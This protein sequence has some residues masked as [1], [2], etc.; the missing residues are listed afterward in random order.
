[1]RCAFA[2]VV[3]FGLVFGNFL[4]AAEPGRQ[5]QGLGQLVVIDPQSGS[6]VRLNLARYH[7]NVVLHPPVA[8]VQIDQSF[9]NPFAMQQEGTFVFNLPAGASVSRFAMYTTHIELVE[10]ELIDRARA[11]DIYQSIVS[12]RRDPAILEQIGDNLFKMRVF[13]IFGR[14][15]KRI[16]LDF[17]LPIVEQE[18][19]KYTFE[20][21]LMSDLE[22]VWDFA[23]TGAIR[24]PNI[25]GTASSP[26]HSDLTFDAAENGGLKF[27]FRKQLYRPESAFVVQ[28]QQK[29]PVEAT[30]RSFATSPPRI[31]KPTDPVQVN[32]IKTERHCEFLATISPQ[33]L[34]KKDQQ[35]GQKPLPADLLILADTSGGIADRE[36]LRLAVQAIV[37]GLRT[38]DRFAV[39]CA[40]VG[41]RA[42]TRGWVA[43]GSPG[44]KEALATFDHELF[45]GETRFE[46]SLA[47]ALEFLP[48]AET[49]R[50]RLVVYVGDGAL[51][52]SGRAPSAAVCQSIVA[53]LAQAQ[54]RLFAV[55][56]ENDPAGR[57][58]FEQ[59]AAAS[60]GQ[61]LRIGAAAGSQE[62]LT[63]WVQAGFAEPIKI[64][65]V[66]AEGVAQDD[67]FVPTAWVLGR[68]LQILGRRKESGP[69]KLEVT[70]ERRGKAESHEWTLE[71]KNDPDDMF[72]GR[73]WAQRK[74]DQLRALEAATDASPARENAVA[75]IVSLSQEWT[76]LSPHTAFL[77]LEN[78][79]EY[80]KYGIT[81]QTRHQYWKPGDAVPYEPLPQ[82]AL[83][84]LTGPPRVASEVTD[85]DF[86][87]VLA[88][89][90]KALADR[91]PR[92]AL[93][94]LETVS[95]SR[96]APES[97]EFEELRQSAV[98][99]LSRSDLLRDLG[100]WRGWFEREHSIGFDV[101]APELVW[102]L[103]YGYGARGHYGDPQLASLAKHVP[104]PAGEMSLR[105]FADWVEDVSGLAVWMDKQTLTDEGINLDQNVLVTGI[106][107]MSLESL[108]KHVLG[109]RQMTHVFENGVLK[110]TTSS[111]A[112]EKLSTRLYPVSDLVLSTNTTDYLLLI[113]AD[114]D[115]ELLTNRRLEEKLDRKVSVDFDDAPL[116]EAFR[117]IAEK[118]EDNFIIDQQTL[119]DEG[120]ALDQ[121]V[122]LQR[123]NVPLRQIL[124]LVCEPIQLTTSIE[125]EAVVVTTS[126]R[127]GE[128]LH[129]RIYSAQG[130]VYE[131]PPEVEK[132]RRQLAVQQLG[133]GGGMGGGMWNGMGG[134][135]MGGPM[136]GGM[137]VCLG[138]RGR[139]R[140]STAHSH[141][142]HGPA[143]LQPVRH[144]RR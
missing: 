8:L 6:P 86:E 45:L 132:K 81:R 103:L 24:G 108:L 13:P 141:W 115:R 138:I 12:R 20:L 66:K 113:N 90:R 7:V 31:E 139:R 63:G 112:G 117:V 50:R 59:L 76:L 35:R 102:R 28:F 126:A 96:L 5:P 68:G 128:K 127:A 25:A 91:A 49:G 29:A 83:A 80:A 106:R 119:T 55:I 104:P 51:P 42:L 135:G 140:P 4:A 37:T 143:R 69:M 95:K 99:L 73:L 134:G 142:I 70:I 17:T 75:G 61:V 10:G 16:L 101:P 39:G 2:V 11:A 97:K 56:Q 136:M 27:E 89:V 48:A 40:D 137:A 9:F 60:G 19:G 100:P 36:R 107:S 111:K 122:T 23:V 94:T 62:E 15:T 121:P 131:L 18:G 133:K 67:L 38:D 58:L 64:V 92:R 118:F 65:A 110:F 52:P 120:V 123:R 57:L 72:V 129:T 22:P 44:A 21:P 78:E 116:Q 105:A 71:L 87:S 46:K 79:S 26:S 53:A 93:N 41:F 74:V 1:M 130:I 114:L 125:D 144:I 33:V 82:E 77:V 84:A 88:K 98:K 85:N 47:G 3:V 14:D 54:A 124:A 109:P 32:K 30:V 34:N 43:A